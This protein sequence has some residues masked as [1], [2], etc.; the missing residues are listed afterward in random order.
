MLN[1]IT[2]NALHQK[3]K[4]FVIFFISDVFASNFLP[5]VQIVSKCTHSFNR[6][7][8][9]SFFFFLAVYRCTIACRTD[10]GISYEPKERKTAKNKLAIKDCNH[11][12]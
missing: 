8:F 6:L 7:Q 9:H 11:Q 5:V 2:L 4:V 3:N 10:L 12:K 1:R